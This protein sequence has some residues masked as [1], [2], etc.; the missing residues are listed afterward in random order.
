MNDYLRSFRAFFAREW[1][2]GRMS[3]S[4]IAFPLLLLAAGLLPIAF[5][6]VERTAQLHLLQALLYLVPLFGVVVGASAAQAEAA[7]GALLGS[8]P[9]SNAGRVAGK[10]CTLALLFALAQV[11]LL[12]P[13]L[14]AGVSPLGLLRLWAYGIGAASVFLSLGLMVGFRSND[15]VRAHLAGLALWLFL[16][17]GFGLLAW[18]LAASGWAKQSPEAWLLLLGASPLEALRVAALFQVEALPFSPDAVVPLGRAWLE[19]PDLWFFGVASLWTI[20]AL[21]LARP[22]RG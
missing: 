6:D 19:H 11:G 10:F 8:L 13:S 2:A 14:I 12:A 18:L 17:F 21:S 16:T 4:L 5:G 1:L 22:R 20:L 7:E 3:R 9:C 15:A